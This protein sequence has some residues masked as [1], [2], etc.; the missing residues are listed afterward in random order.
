MFQWATR[1]WVWL[2]V[3]VALISAVVGLRREL[4]LL[5]RT[6]HFLA[7]T[8]D[9]RNERLDRRIDRIYLPPDEN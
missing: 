5:R 4:D 9:Y 6:V 7:I 3:L 2:V 8:Q 1:D